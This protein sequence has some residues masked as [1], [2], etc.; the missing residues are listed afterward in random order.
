MEDV[1]FVAIVLARMGVPL[2]IPRFP[3]PAIIASL[4]I[5]AADQTIFAA[6]DVEPDN[7]QSY[8]KALDIYYL[9]IAYISTVRNWTDGPAFRTGQFLWY[10]RLV[11]VVAF[12]LSG[13]RALLLIFPN[14]FEYF[15]I[16][17]ESVRLWWNPRRLGQAAVIGAA[18]AIWVGIKLP[19]EWWI[20][21]AQL[22]VTD[23]VGE[24]PWVWPVLAVIVVVAL[25]LA[26]R[27]L[28]M[29]PETDW[30]PNVD[31]DANR[32][33]ALHATVDPPSGRLALINH[34]LIEKTI[35]VGLVTTIFWQLI[36]NTDQSLVEIV[37]GVA[38]IV[39]INS[40]VSGWLAGRGTS[41]AVTGAS[42][43]GTGAINLGIVLGL[44]LLAPGNDAANLGGLLTFFELSLLT[45]MGTLY[46][47]YRQLR[48]AAID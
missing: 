27:M 48:L 43:V 13:T 17:Y 2:L 9:A 24:N 31:V 37:L 41:W 7:Y 8:D 4:V 19:Q 15:F 36:P 44:R 42:F 32:T 38:V 10:Y 35:L 33:T 18:A 45:L 29:L 28:P 12:E 23:F 20:H 39:I 14:T 34:P 22:D 47:R 30:S 5:D 25:L 46:D 21:I 16:F 6:F 1:V 40:W 11:G 26:R 3:L